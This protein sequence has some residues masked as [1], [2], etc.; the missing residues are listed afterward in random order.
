MQAEHVFI[1]KSPISNPDRVC[2]EGPR[3][4][5]DIVSSP[6]PRTDIIDILGVQRRIGI[7]RWE[8]TAPYDGNMRAQHGESRGWSPWPPPSAGRACRSRPASRLVVLIDEPKNGGSRIALNVAIYDGVFFAPLKHA[9]SARTDRGSRQLRGRVARGLNRTITFLPRQHRSGSAK[10]RA[11]LST[12]QSMAAMPSV[13]RRR[14]NALASGF[15][16]R[17]QGL[18][19]A[20]PS[21]IPGFGAR[22]EGNPYLYVNAFR[23]SAIICCPLSSRRYQAVS[24]MIDRCLPAAHNEPLR[25]AFAHSSRSNEKKH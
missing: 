17:L 7:G 19:A 13:R 14:A 15:Q 8:V 9:A 24:A 2:R 23:R 3:A 6:W 11:C 22:S 5:P 1:G 4:I 25:P 21:G 18:P 10:V 20:D 16:T 12:L